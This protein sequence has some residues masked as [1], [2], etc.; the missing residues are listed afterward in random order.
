MLVRPPLRALLLAP[1]LALLMA[2]PHPRVES[3]AARERV[4]R[5]FPSDLFLRMRALP[6]GTIPS[7]RIATAV[8]QLQFERAL[9]A[10]TTA[11]QGVQDWVSVGPFNVGGR[12][13]A[14]V[15]AAGGAPAFLGSANGGVFRSDDLGTNWQPLTD[16]NGLFSIGA[17]ALHPTNANTVWAGTGDANGTV[18]GYDGTGV[19]VSRDGG[20]HWV[21]RGL[22]NTS[23]ISSLAI[24]P[25]DSNVVLAGAM[26]KAFTTDPNRGLYRSTDGGATWTR[27]LFVNGFIGTTPIML[28]NQT[29]ARGCQRR[30]E[31]QGTGVADA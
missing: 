19:Y 24:S 7:E 3:E 15:A 22:R 4:E 26:G 6:D 21:A 14:L 2:A 10:R 27:T 11:A 1:V 29:R 17:L 30:L 28:Q 16:A 25:T 31:D 20:R 23:R 18:D 13:N 9:R 12:V 8:E 5:E